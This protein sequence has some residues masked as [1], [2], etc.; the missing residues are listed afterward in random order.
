MTHTEAFELLK[1]IPGSTY[2][3]ADNYLEVPIT[4]MSGIIINPN[5]FTTDGVILMLAEGGGP[6]ATFDGWF[7]DLDQSSE[8]AF[9]ESFISYW[10]ANL[11]DWDS[12]AIESFEQ[13]LADPE[14]VEESGYTEEEVQEFY[15]AHEIIRQAYQ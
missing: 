6:N 5:S 10:H 14:F 1:T 3:P 7:S 13:D 12:C 2:D 15:D 8:E 9:I 4:S 11:W